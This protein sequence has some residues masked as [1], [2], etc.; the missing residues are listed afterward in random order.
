[1]LNINK[2]EEVEF[3]EDNHLDKIIENIRAIG[4]CFRSSTNNSNSL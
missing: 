2:K 4:N 1:M 3:E